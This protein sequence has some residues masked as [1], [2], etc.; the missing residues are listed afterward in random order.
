MSTLIEAGEI[1]E[2]TGVKATVPNGI[3]HPITTQQAH[4]PKAAR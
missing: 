3:R 2:L 4:S 1:N